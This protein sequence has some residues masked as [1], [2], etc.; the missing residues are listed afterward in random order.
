MTSL[1]SLL[2]MTSAIVSQA[3]SSSSRP[4]INVVHGRS[5]TLFPSSS[6]AD[7]ATSCPDRLKSGRTYGEFTEYIEGLA[8]F[9][10]IVNRCITLRGSEESTIPLSSFTDLGSGSG[11]VVLEAS[12]LW[13]TMWRSCRGIEVSMSLHNNA[14]AAHE[15]H[16][17]L[18]PLQSATLRDSCS[19]IQASFDDP[20]AAD[21]LADTDIAFA[22]STAFPSSPSHGMEWLARS[23][24][25]LP[26]G[27]LVVTVDNPL[28]PPTMPIGEESS[29]FVL[30]EKL[31]GKAV[32]G[33]VGLD[34]TVFIYERRFTR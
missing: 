32:Y 14:L 12:M 17:S 6:W 4:L 23:L 18:P 24:Q 1:P 11:R 2:L 19:F 16:I 22:Y 28:L 21:V 10:K 34:A 3:L 7:R 13:P 33:S 26:N 9:E 15:R 8:F 27:S 29:G 30:K 31:T 5:S 25:P 20:T